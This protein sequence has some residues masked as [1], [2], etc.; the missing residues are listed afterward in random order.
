MNNQRD[1]QKTGLNSY[2]QSNFASVNALINKP[3]R[4]ATDVAGG[5]VYEFAN[6]K[7]EKLVTALYMVTDCMETD[8]ALK[9][10]LRL[11]GVQLLSNIYELNIFKPGFAES[12]IR[13]SLNNIYEIFSFIDI[14]N[15]MGYISEMN[16]NILKK[17]FNLLVEELSSHLPKEK[18][19][20]FT[21]DEKMFNIS[22]EV[23]RTENLSFKENQIKRTNTMSFINNK[24]S[25][26]VLYKPLSFIDHKKVKSDRIEKI[27]SIIKDKN[28][29]SIKDI[30]VA[31]PDCSEKTIQRE[32]N[33]LIEK[34]QIKKSGD[35]RWSRYSVLISEQGL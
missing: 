22:P 25:S 21:L 23:S 20:P 13:A 9:G 30:S 11:L 24:T 15:T 34:G 27:I 19:F 18:S 17:E 4:S 26:N 33:D 7:T 10:K 14:S 5:P 2:G 1:T 29:A 32:L 8:D 12:H 35:K 3:A 28:E 6:K 16:T 31:F